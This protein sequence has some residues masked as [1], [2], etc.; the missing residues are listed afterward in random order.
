M[1]DITQLPRW[2]LYGLVFLFVS[3][4]GVFLRILFML[5]SKTIDRV[6]EQMHSRFD[7][8]KEISKKHDKKFQLLFIHQEATDF[9]LNEKLPGNGVKGFL[10][11]KTERMKE[12]KSNQKFLDD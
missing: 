6:Q 7:E 10:K 5:A 3:L 12:L 8:Q 2:A 4:S 11:L 9:A 1:F